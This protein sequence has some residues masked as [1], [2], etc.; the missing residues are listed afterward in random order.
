[1]L[2]KEPL[3]QTFI[4]NGLETP[5]QM[6]QRYLDF[7]ENR[8]LLY[9][10]N[11]VKH[12]RLKLPNNLNHL[13]DLKERKEFKEELF[14]RWKHGHDG[15]CGM[16]YAHYNYMT[17]HDRAT[18]GMI[19]PDYRHYDNLTFSLIESCMGRPNQYFED[20]SGKGIIYLSRRGFGKSATLG[21]AAISTISTRK[22][23]TTLLTS[24]DEKDVEKF[25]QEKVKMTYYKMKPYLRFSELT[26]NRGN[27]HIGKETQTK[28][29][30]TL[31]AG[32]NSKMVCK[33][34][35]LASLEGGGAILAEIDEAGKIKGL[36]DIIDNL[37]PA[38]CGKDGITRVGLP[39]VAGVAGETDVY[40]T[41]YGDL[42]EKAKERD[43]LQ[44]FV[45]GWA[46]IRV[47]ELGNDDIEQ[48]VEMIFT[49]RLKAQSISES[50]L[51]SHL[52]QYPLTPEEALNSSSTGVLNRAR[53]REQCAVLGSNPK[54]TRTGTMSWL[55]KA[56]KHPNFIP[57]INGKVE[58]LENPIQSLVAQGKYIGFIDAYD[59]KEKNEKSAN[60]KKDTNSGSV[61][62]FYVFKRDAGLSQGEQ[63]AIFDEL[64]AETEL[65]KKKALHLALGHLPVA[66]YI[67]G[68]DKPEDFAEECAKLMY[69]Y[70]CKTLVERFPSGIYTYLMNYYKSLMQYKPVLPGERL[71]PENFQKY[72]IK[73]TEDWKKERTSYLQWYFNNCCDRIYFPRLLGDADDYDPEVQ[74]KKKDSVDAFGG[75]LLHDK[76]PY[77]RDGEYE[78][79]TGNDDDVLFGVIDDGNGGIA[80]LNG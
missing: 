8:D 30:L 45:P 20:N 25:L 69:L 39:L 54:S 72:G 10:K 42:W 17:I 67:E 47:D 43:F 16:M 32:N 68:Q 53:I 80:W 4:P 18:G 66:E 28:D 22:E 57:N 38:L 58:I 34:P 23:V 77:L 5:K 75:C 41:D 14:R 40:G 1:M 9:P 31:V 76:Q 49:L 3:N 19:Q 64:A 73:I 7:L 63:K 24:K 56:S 61:G 11:T 15:M 35:T 74:R 59:I 44:W 13:K 79:G 52:K 55:D 50:K 71:K 70:G 46:G 2:I 62:A 21:S 29:G 48:A 37:L 51:I 36:V 65:E 27:F 6:T 12:E 33:A 26:N 60:S 78:V